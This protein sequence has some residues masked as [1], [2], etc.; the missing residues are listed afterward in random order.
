MRLSV[1]LLLLLWPGVAHA[2]VSHV[3]I[4]SNVELK[5][6]DSKTITVESPTPVELGWEAI[7]AKPCTMNC[8]EAIDKTSGTNCT[9]A[10]SI[11]ASMKYT[12]V[13][14]KII[15]EYHNASTD[16]VTINIFKLAR[17]CTAESCAFVDANK[18]GKWLVI[19]VGKFQSIEMSKD[20]SYSTIT[21]VTLAGKPFSVK[22]LWWTDDPKNALVNCSPSIQ[23]YLANK[24]PPADYSPYIISGSSVGDGNN[25]ILKS[26]DTCAPSAPKFGVPEENVYK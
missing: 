20:N 24:T 2:E 21:G 15:V 3:A 19:K 9:I 7:Q 16:P 14:G 11:G 18:E 22:A 25:L 6:G 23:K 26:I 5:P 17:T 13:D 4:E 12:P 1:L 8:V 10:T